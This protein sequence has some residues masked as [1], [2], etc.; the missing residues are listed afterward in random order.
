MGRGMRNGGGGPWEHEAGIMK[1]RELGEVDFLADGK[2]A[3]GGGDDGEAESAQND[4]DLWSESLRTL[5]VS[6]GPRPGANE[7][8]QVVTLFLQAHSCRRIV[9]AS[10]MFGL[11]H[12]APPRGTLDSS[13]PD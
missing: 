6:V 10:S 3:V 12:Q 9:L 13:I 2:M 5:R 4:E 8:P 7:G 11:H 1:L